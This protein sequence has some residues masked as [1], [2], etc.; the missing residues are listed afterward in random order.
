[1]YRTAGKGPHVPR[2]SYLQDIIP[3]E[4]LRHILILLQPLDKF[5]LRLT[6]HRMYEAVSDPATWRPLSFDY[7]HTA[8]RKALD[9]TLDLCSPGVKCLEI[10]TQ[11][12]I[13]RFPWARFAK[14][15]SKCSSSLQHLSLLGLSPSPKQLYTSFSTLSVLSHITLEIEWAKGI[16][17]PC[18]PSLKYF[19]VQLQF[20]Y[21]LISPL[22]A[23]SHNN[24]FPQTFAITSRNHKTLAKS[25][26]EVQRFV[27]SSDIQPLHTTCVFQAVRCEGPLNVFHRY[28]FLEVIF[29]DSG[30]SIPV[31]I[32]SSITQSPLIQVVS[33]PKC[34]FRVP[35][36]SQQ[37]P[38]VCRITQFSVVAPTLAHLVLKG[39]VDVTSE[40]LDEIS[41][42]CP[43]LKFL[44]LN[45]CHKALGSL[46]GLTNI[47]GRCLQLEGLDLS[48]IHPTVDRSA[49][50]DILSGFRR[51]LYLTVE[52]CF[53]PLEGTAPCAKVNTLLFLQI[54]YTVPSQIENCIICRT[55]CDKSLE[56]LGQL[57]PERLKVLWMSEQLGARFSVTGNG[58]SHLL[59]LLPSLQ[60]L[61]IDTSG[62]FLL[63]TE[64]GC[65][66]SIEKIS[67]ICLSCHVTTEFVEGLIKNKCLTH[68]YLSVKSIQLEAVSRLVQA[69]RLVCLHIGC[70]ERPLGSWKSKAY[71]AAK[72]ENV[73]DFSMHI[74]PSVSI[75]T[76]PDLMSLNYPVL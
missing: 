40:S 35:A 15:V 14:H 6:C 69:P 53:L 32:C 31:T 45:G 42:H 58:L 25:L 60:C 64:S 34:A 17:F 37:L 47:S 26:S 43:Q 67:L 4:I 59:L 41:C 50:W 33:D 49:L 27:D 12:L 46:N 22:H 5:R 2:V 71:K 1:M 8:S 30:C 13:N 75:R 19:E 3:P 21:D 73:T 29:E 51:L 56:R 9:A 24:F 63:P 65:Y 18:V 38:T 10:N 62:Y 72:A 54:G 44:S 57:L 52:L 36:D 66:R 55:V 74:L 28:P 61:T 70:L 11:H 20:V 16:Y 68:C 7:Y 76:H 48:N 23:W 39:C